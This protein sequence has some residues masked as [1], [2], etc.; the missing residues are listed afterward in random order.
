MQAGGF[1]HFILNGE[2]K[3]VILLFL[4]SLLPRFYEIKSDL[5]LTTPH[6]KTTIDS[7]GTRLRVPDNLKFT[8]FYPIS[9]QYFPIVRFLQT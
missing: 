3:K 1:A 7:S 8:L 5:S 4:F 6:E 9:Q 2:F